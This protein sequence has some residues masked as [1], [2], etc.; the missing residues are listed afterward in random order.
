MN[1]FVAYVPL[2]RRFAFVAG[3]D[4]EAAPKKKARKKRAFE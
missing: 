3:N 4:E 1:C 2:R